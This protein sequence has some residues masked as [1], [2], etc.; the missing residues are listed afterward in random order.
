M[1]VKQVPESEIPIQIDDFTGWIKEDTITEFRMNR[2]DEY[3]VEEALLIKES[4]VG[5]RIDVI[6]VGPARCDEV[7]RRAVG[8]GAD[9]GVHIQTASEGYQSSLEV[10]AW[11][12]DFARGKNY[13]LILTGVMSE[14][15]MQGQVG[16]MLATRLGFSWA[17][18]VIFEKIASDKKS[19]YVEREIEGGH[20][21]TLKLKLPA[22]ITIQS[23]INTPRWPSLSNLLRA[24]SQELERIDISAPAKFQQ[25][26]YLAEVVYPQKSRAGLVLSGSLQEKADHLLMILREK[27][28]L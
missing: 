17:T 20:R 23:G 15:S 18:S 13:A 14:D 27:S 5:T 7:V 19:I 25:M 16:P 4:I 11:I 28:L 6:T 21:D 24:N 8:M 3:A 1:C 10:A 22:V 12:A 2:L 9:Y 26:E